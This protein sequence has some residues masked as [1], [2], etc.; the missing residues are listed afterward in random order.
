[1]LDTCIV[2]SRNIYCAAVTL[3]ARIASTANSARSRLLL[4]MSRLLQTKT[5]YFG[6]VTEVGD[7]SAVLPKYPSTSVSL[8]SH[9]ILKNH[10]SELHQILYTLPMTGLARLLSA[11]RY[12]I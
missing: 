3:L 2:S 7:S 12:A 5:L 6:S 10:T 1:M 11:S 9:S 4:Q 8:Y